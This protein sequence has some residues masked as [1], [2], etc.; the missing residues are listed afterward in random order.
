MKMNE[1]VGK[2]ETIE[3]KLNGDTVSA[4]AGETIIQGRARA[5]AVLLPP[6]RQGHGGLQ[7][8]R[9]RR[10]FAEDGGRAPDE[11]R[12]ARR[13]QARRKRALPLGG[14]AGRRALALRGAPPAGLRRFASRDDGEPRCL[15]PVHA[16]RARLPRGAGERRHR[17]RL[18]RPR[19]EDRVRFR[20]SHGRVHVRRLRRV[21]AGV[22]HGCVGAR[23]ERLQ[24]RRRQASRLG[25]PVL[26][27]GLPAHLS[28]EGQRHR[29]RG[30][31][32]RP[33]QPRAPVREG[34]LRLRLCAASAA[35]HQAAHPEARRA[36]DRGFH[37]RPHALE[38][39][40]PRSHLGRGA[41]PRRVGPEEDS[42]YER[43]E[44]ARRL[45]QRQGLQRGGVS[46]PEAGAHRLRHQ[47][48]R[49]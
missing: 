34:P 38:R 29:A 23:E 4:F 48:R 5:R 40:V 36:Q 37:R 24:S 2:A 44:R 20:R 28:R 9:A 15:H 7:Q 22:P 39:R 43:P 30:G 35:P 19:L 27:R 3:F 14:R 26:R 16:L 33:L 45:R 31:P 17:L 10:A 21:R 47:Q 49:P 18:P 12:A 8:Q 6:A 11:R 25:L 1:P 13:P 32:R 46:L 41:G 42:R